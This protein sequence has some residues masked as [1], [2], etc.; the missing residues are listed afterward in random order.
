MARSSPPTT[1]SPRLKGGPVRAGRGA[2][3]VRRGG[4]ALSEAAIDRLFE[5]AEVLSE[6]GLRPAEEA[7]FGS[8]MLTID[9]AELAVGWRE[10][11]HD[12]AAWSRLLGTVEGSVRF[13]LRLLRLARTEMQHRLRG[14]AP[15]TMV[16]ETR[17]RILDG[18]LQAD[19]DVEAPVDVSSRRRQRQG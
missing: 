12:R 1:R 10:P 19:V 4:H 6:G 16:A 18:K 3:I 7:Y 9:L 13:H 15:G 17:F 14:I 2:K 8:T 11:L 5:I